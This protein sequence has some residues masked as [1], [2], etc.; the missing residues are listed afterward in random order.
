MKKFLLYILL[1]VTCYS[2]YNA[3]QE[4]D[5][6]NWEKLA[7]FLP[8]E[9]SLEGFQRMEVSGEQGDSPLMPHA[10]VNFS[11][12][13][14][15]DKGEDNSDRKEIRLTIEICDA[16]LN[17]E[18]AQAMLEPG[19]QSQ[20]VSKIY[21][22]YPAVIGKEIND[23][24]YESCMIIF[25]VDNRFLI[26]INGEGT[27]DLNLVNKLIEKIELEELRKQK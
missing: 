25:L 3:Y 19:A 15:S 12:S 26:S 14:G 4:K 23:F 10:Y 13:T 22:K 11:K 27:S 7:E 18:Y 24:G 17:P 1:L 16:L 8:A 6:V 20:Y 5:P 9:N 2:T 21:D